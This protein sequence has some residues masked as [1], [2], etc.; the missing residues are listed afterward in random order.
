MRRQRVRDALD[1]SGCAHTQD[2]DPNRQHAML[3]PG[4]RQHLPGDE[5]RHGDVHAAVNET[6]S[7]TSA[8]QPPVQ[9][10][11][12]DRGSERSGKLEHGDGPYPRCGLTYRTDSESFITFSPTSC[13]STALE[14]GS[15]RDPVRTPRHDC[16]AL[17]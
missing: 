9:E 17:S 8:V 14:L 16:A 12:H 1:E 5:Y 15:I 3:G 6:H 13:R 7:A 2:Q 11:T 4:M 10:R